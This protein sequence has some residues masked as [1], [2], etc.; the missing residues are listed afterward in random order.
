MQR[1]TP[2]PGPQAS[3]AGWHGHAKGSRAYGR[4][5]LGLAFAGV[6]TF[7]QLYSTQAVLPILA[8]DLKISAAEA[9][10]TI[11]LATVGL[12]VTVIPWSFL[13]DRIGRVK[14]MAWGISVATILGLLVPL[15]TSFPLLLGLRLLEG[16]ALG[17]IPAIAIAYLNEEV[18]KAHA[19]VAAGSYVA[20]TTLGGLA[21]RLVAGPAGELW[22]W[23]AAALAVSILATL[24]AVAFLVLVPRAR[25]FTAAKAPGLRGAARTLGGHVRNIRL[26]ALYIQAFLM[27]GGFVAVYN[28]LGF[29]LTGEPY[30]L[31][32]TVISLMFLAYLSGTITSRWAAGL[33][34]RFGRRN[35]L[36]AGLAL[37]TAGLALTLTPSLALILAGLVIFTGGFFAAHSIGA[38][39]TGAIAS[40]GRAQAA[41][42]YNLAYYLGSSII[43]WAGGLLFQS[44]GWNALAAAVM[45]LACL[46]AVTV[47][48]VHP[49]E[50]TRRKE[51]GA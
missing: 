40:T 49:R 42:L 36:L 15:S 22:G 34:L 13:A 48:V 26:L 47:A 31:P 33:T 44:C 50:A 7:A 2:I 6:A 41:S 24:A 27:M 32:A 5:I 14:A 29:R 1:S 19:A 17:G 11:S 3:D 30:G 20:G 35:V 18:T 8:S 9:A 10:L 25:G 23:R 38:G 43:G 51:A 45:T 37:S 4:I 28:Y 16:M 46:T 39:W 21:G 12:A